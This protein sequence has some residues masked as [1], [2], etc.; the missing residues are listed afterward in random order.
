MDRD[1][2]PIDALV[3]IADF[4]NH[5]YPPGIEWN[6]MEKDGKKGFFMYATRDIARGS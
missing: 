4:F 2:E 5:D 1:K 3:P 6:Y